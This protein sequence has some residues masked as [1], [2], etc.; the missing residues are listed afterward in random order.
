[1]Y[2]NIIADLMA[3]GFGGMTSLDLRGGHSSQEKLRHEKEATTDDEIGGPDA[4]KVAVLLLVGA[5]IFSLF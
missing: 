4:Y 5:V 1:M 3:R 2:A